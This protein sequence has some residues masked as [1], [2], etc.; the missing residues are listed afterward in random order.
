MI[1]AA[2][3]EKCK[4]K[5]ALRILEKHTCIR[6]TPYDYDDDF[7]WIR[8]LT[9]CSSFIGRQGGGQKISLDRSGCVY[10]ST[11]QHEIIHALGYTHMQNHPDRDK[12][13]TIYWNNIQSS[14]RHNFKKVE[15]WKYSNFNTPYDYY[16][17]MHY[18]MDN[19]AIN[20][21]Y[22]TL[23]P[24]DSKYRNIVGK[25][26]IISAGDARRINRMYQ[27]KNVFYD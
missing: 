5:N 9:G 14:K 7:I 16:S 11:I 6:F 2:N 17:V 8:D 21:K 19:F 4:I 26:D 24:T 22:V 23:Y 13:I 1:F 10:Q 18:D 15:Q 27:C 12:Y 3:S 20:T 25:R